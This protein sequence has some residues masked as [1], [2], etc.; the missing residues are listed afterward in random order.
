M[1]DEKKNDIQINRLHIEHSVYYA[2]QEPEGEHD[3]PPT[4]LIAAHGYGQACKNFI[5]T[6]VDEFESVLTAGQDLE[7]F[8]HRV[9]RRLAAVGVAGL[10]AVQ[11]G[12]LPFEEE[13]IYQAKW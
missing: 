2:V 4:L 10:L 6:L 7:S 8:Q 12:I 5:R 3:E 11:A 9:V 1:A 13:E